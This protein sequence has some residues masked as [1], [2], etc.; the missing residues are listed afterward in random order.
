VPA[1]LYVYSHRY[2]DAHQYTNRYGHRDTMRACSMRANQYPYAVRRLDRPT[3]HSD[4]Y[5]YLPPWY[6]RLPADR[7]ADRDSHRNGH[8]VHRL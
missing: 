7:Y 4:A 5:A 3:L 6:A 2:D 1:N 8:A